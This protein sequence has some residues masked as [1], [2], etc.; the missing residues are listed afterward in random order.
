MYSDSSVIPFGYRCSTRLFLILPPRHNLLSPQ[1][2][3]LTSFS[4]SVQFHWLIVPHLLYSTHEYFFHPFWKTSYCLILPDRWESVS[5]LWHYMSLFDP[6]VL[7]APYILFRI[8]RNQSMTLSSIPA[9]SLVSHSCF[10]PF[11][12]LIPLYYFYIR[13]SRTSS[14]LFFENAGVPSFFIICQTME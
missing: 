13:F 9:I 6:E 5:L 11:F 1:H 10:L 4:P 8:H 2:G 12:C 14:L 3:W 7:F